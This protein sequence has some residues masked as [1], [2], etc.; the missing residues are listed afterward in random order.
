M[1]TTLN[2]PNPVKPGTTIEVPF[3]TNM[4]ET[5]YTSYDDVDK[6]TKV[7][8]D[9]WDSIAENTFALQNEKEYKL[10]K[11]HILMRES[12]RTVGDATGADAWQALEILI[13]E[14]QGVK[15]VTDV[16]ADWD[17][18]TGYSFIIH[19]TGPFEVP[20]NLAVIEDPFVFAGF[21]IVVKETA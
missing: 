16:T 6:A 17:S 19:S 8:T 21:P 9:L 11:H 5:V 7:L 10:L 12:G 1:K 15:N 2:W 13:R 3:S 4:M 18:E 20:E 14:C